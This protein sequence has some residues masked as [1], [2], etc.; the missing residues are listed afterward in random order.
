MNFAPPSRVIGI[1]LMVAGAVAVFAE[2]TDVKAALNRLRGWS[3]VSMP[4]LNPSQKTRDLTSTL[5]RKLL[6]TL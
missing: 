5:R 6:W 1:A 4:N 2:G 3:C